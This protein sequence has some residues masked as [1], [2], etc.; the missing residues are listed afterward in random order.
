M[1]VLVICRNEEDQISNKA[2]RVVIRLFFDFSRCSRAANSVVGD[3]I[4][5]KFKLIQVFI[6]VLVTCK[7]E[8]DLSENE[9]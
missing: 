3:G 5:T 9:H 1:V 4:L 6:V 7:S 2:A 8:E